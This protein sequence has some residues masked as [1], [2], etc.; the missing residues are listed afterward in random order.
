MVSLVPIVAFMT[1]FGP[2]IAIAVFNFGQYDLDAA[3]QLGSVL[4]WGAFHADPVRDDAGAAAGVL[5]PRG[6]RGPRR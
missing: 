2:A 4:S 5:R 1:F 3:D 6:I